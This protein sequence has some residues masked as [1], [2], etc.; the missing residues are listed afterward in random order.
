[1]SLNHLYKGFYKSLKYLLR[2]CWLFNPSILGTIPSISKSS[3][4]ELSALVSSILSRITF[5]AVLPT[6]N[7]SFADTGCIALFTVSVNKSEV[8]KSNCSSSSS[9]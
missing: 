5:I 4:L 2:I 9:Y 8:S 1:L 3:I 6:N 7:C